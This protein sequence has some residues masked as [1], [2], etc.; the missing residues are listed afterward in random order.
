MLLQTYCFFSFLC[1]GLGEG[2]PALIQRRTCSKEA[3]KR[4]YVQFMYPSFRCRVKFDCGQEIQFLQS[5][6]LEYKAKQSWILQLA[7]LL[8]NKVSHEYISTTN[9]F[10]HCIKLIIYMEEI[11]FSPFSDRSSSCNSSPPLARTQLLMAGT[12]CRMPT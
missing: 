9:S 1:V 4:K 11:A 7:Q 2:D 5:R 10:R 8:H 6:S 3:S 12:K